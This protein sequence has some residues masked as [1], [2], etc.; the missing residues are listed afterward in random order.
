MI[1]TNFTIR[2][3]HIVGAAVVVGGLF[4]V[5]RIQKKISENINLVNPASSENI[6]N[7]G[8]VS[9][10]GQS[11]IDSVSDVVFGAIDLIN[12]FNESDVHARRVFGLGESNE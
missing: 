2:T 4:T 3:N 10:V 5:W 11:N 8:V 12:P 9:V 7:Q 1:K 6:V